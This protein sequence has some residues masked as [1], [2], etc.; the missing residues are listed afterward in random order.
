MILRLK[1]QHV[2]SFVISART[3][4]FATRLEKPKVAVCPQ[5]GEIS[6]Y[7]EHVDQLRKNRG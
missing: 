4:V 2:A 5:C 6:L 3:G 1:V 7:I